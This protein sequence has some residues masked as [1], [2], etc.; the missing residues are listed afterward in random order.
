ML[1]LGNQGVINFSEVHRGPFLELID[2]KSNDGRSQG[3]TIGC[4][5]PAH[6]VL[7]PPPPPY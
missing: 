2:D 7:T 1:K 5:S 6:R 4:V 3:Q